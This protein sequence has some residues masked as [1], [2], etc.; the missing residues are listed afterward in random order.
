MQHGYLVTEPRTENAAH[1]EGERDLWHEND[2]SLAEAQRFCD[3]AQ[4]HFRLAAAGNSVQQADGEFAAGRATL[5]IQKRRVLDRCSVRSLA[6]CSRRRRKS[7]S[8]A[9]AASSQ[10]VSL[11]SRNIRSMTAR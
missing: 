8:S 4:I 6:R 5:A 11:P 2:R 9:M 3:G 10:D 1:P 7:S